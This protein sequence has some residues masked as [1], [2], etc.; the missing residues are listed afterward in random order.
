MKL[1]RFAGVITGISM[2]FS[3]PWLHAGE[4]QWLAPLATGN[5]P[6]CPHNP[7]TRNYRS[8]I[9]AAVSTRIYVFGTTI[10]NRSGCHKRAEIRVNRHGQQ[11]IFPLPHADAWDFQVVDYSP[12]GS[13]ILLA[14]NVLD[15]DD[16][17]Q[18]RD[19]V[20]S[21][22]DLRTGKTDW[23][24]A[25]DLFHWRDCDAMVEPQGFMPDGRLVLMARQSVIASQV[26]PNCVQDKALYAIDLTSGKVSRLPDSTIVPRTGHEV[27]PEFQACK[28]D[29]DIVGECFQIHGRLAA[30][31]GSPTLRIWHVGTSRILGVH[32]D[33]LPETIS[34]KMDWDTEILGDFLVC[35]YTRQKEGAMQFVCVESVS[36]P[37]VRVRK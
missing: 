29:P 10:H 3:V 7:G 25:W 18:R 6:D 27:R 33:I 13:K 28:S 35:P 16:R 22:M 30:Y 26:N 1:V 8:E 24:N 32:N 5:A 4:P 34:P 19:V 31:N 21:L 12:D 36:K 11:K 23:H 17:Y 15:D 14:S 2:L 9:V 20:V 37:V